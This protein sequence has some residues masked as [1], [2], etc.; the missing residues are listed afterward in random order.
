MSGGG[1][2]VE[3]AGVVPGVVP[4]VTPSVFA[5]C[6]VGETQAGPFGRAD[7]AVESCRSKEMRGGERSV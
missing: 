4:G 3:V 5:V 6:G 7:S 1:R 2:C